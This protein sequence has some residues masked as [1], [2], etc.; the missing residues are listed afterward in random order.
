MPWKFLDDGVTSDL[1]IVATGRDL[2]ELFAAAAAAVTTAM[3]DDAATTVAAR[4]TL[5]AVVNAPALD[6][7]L[8]RFLDELI[9]HKDA[10]GLILRA[11]RVH[12]EDDETHGFTVRAELVGEQI[13]PAKHALGADVK[14][15]TL[16]GLRVE[17]RPGG[18]EAEV[19][20]DV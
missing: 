15:V 17:R 20:L 16:Y 13:D 9:F 6:L 10:R 11:E 2:D 14:A 19:T 18:W 8:L 1:T 7:L 3:V 5:P 4:L 12:V